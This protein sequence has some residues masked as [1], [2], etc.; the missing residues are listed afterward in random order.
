MAA[1]QKVAA[2]QL[3]EST[4]QDLT[5]DKLVH[6]YERLR[7]KWK[8][9]SVAK[10]MQ[11]VFGGKKRKRSKVKDALC[12]GIGSFSRDWQHRWRSL[13]QLVL[14]LDAAAQVQ[15]KDMYAQDPAFT[16]LDVEFLARL[17]VGHVQ[18]GIEQYMSVE[19]FVFS[20]F[21]DWCILLPVFLKGKDPLWYVG[22][23]ILH[24]YTAYAQTTDKED[25]LQ[26][27]NELGDK[28][29]HNR[30]RLRLRDLEAHAHALNGMVVYWKKE[31]EEEE[32]EEE[33]DTT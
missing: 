22:N 13:W 26:E 2:G 21:V 30:E 31:E 19:S 20:P 27:C 4:V 18:T 10:Q 15:A 33:K 25:K 6:E 1:T 5:A 8:D 32:E 16:P 7:E 17:G 24:D 9:A 3:P 14:F 29:L 12:I 11:D 28:F 23:E